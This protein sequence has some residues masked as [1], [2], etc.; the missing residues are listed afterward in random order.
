MNTM[1]E[2]RGG[3]WYELPDGRKVQ[4]RQ[5]AFLALAARTMGLST[6]AETFTLERLDYTRRAGMQ[7]G[8]DRDIYKVAGYK[9]APSFMDYWEY[10]DRHPIAGR[11]VDLAAKTTWRDPPEIVEPEKED[12]TKFTRAFAELADR[13]DLWSRFERADRLGRIG[14]FSIILLG[15]RDGGSYL[16]KPLERLSKP[17]DIVYLSQFSERY[18]RVAKWVD[19]QEDERFGLPEIYE[20]DLSRKN[21]TFKAGRQSVHW[22]RVLHIAEDPLEDDVYGRPILKRV[23]NTIFND[24][25]VDAASAEAF[26][27]LADQIL[28][29]KID[30]DVQIP[31]DDLS[32]IDEKLQLLYHDLRKHFYLQGGELSWLGGE[33]VDPSA[34]SD[35]LTTKMAAGSGYPRRILFGSEQG[36]L[37]SSQDERNYLGTISERQEQHAEPNFVRAFINRLIELGVLPPPGENGY[38]VIWP[39]LYKATDQEK[40]ETNKARADTAKS[41]TAIGGDPYELVTVDEEGLVSL[42]HSEEVWKERAAMPEPDTGT[43]EGSEPP[44]DGEEGDGEEPEEK[45]VE[46]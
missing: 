34:I 29:L 11:I 5:A 10:Y 38:T 35:I 25:K 17:E 27:Q 21:T 43:E 31:E 36:E 18:V 23:L 37:A 39:E 15:V 24:E 22:S 32:E 26:W 1:P 45:P 8:G 30:K 44:E 2:Y 19:D 3:G 7:F 9:N 46:E 4:G 40:A 12:G 42:R 13:L 14:R 6:E 20:V 16:G 41:L 28:Q 33:T